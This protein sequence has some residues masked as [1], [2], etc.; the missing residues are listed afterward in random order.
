MARK[1][2]PISFYATTSNSLG[3]LTR[4]AFRAFTR[5]LERRTL[6]YGVSAGQWRFLR[7]LWTEEGLTQRELSRR[8]GILEPA[9]VIAIEGLEKAGFVR[10]ERSSE[11]RRR[12]HVYLTPKAKALE[13]ELLPHIAE[14]NELAVRGMSEAKIAML[15]TLLA[16]ITENLADDYPN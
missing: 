16:Q 14:V 12:V 11:D 5:S 3:F 9:V 6:P 4:M 1:P 15:R 7:A 10:R 8:V 2:P 13:A